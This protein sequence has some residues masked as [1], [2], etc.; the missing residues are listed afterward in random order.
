MCVRL[1][2]SR[3]AHVFAVAIS[4]PVR[5]L[6]VVPVS[7]LLQCLF[8]IVLLLPLSFCSLVLLCITVCCGQNTVL[9]SLR[10]SLSSVLSDGLY[11]VCI[12]YLCCVVCPGLVNI[13]VVCAGHTNRPLSW[14][15]GWDTLRQTLCNTFRKQTS[16]ANMPI[17]EH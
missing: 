12:K 9:L 5:V 8:I 3:S 15:G 7:C 13:P 14:W 17:P 11:K 10:S 2:E 4:S 16:H 1:R 6:P